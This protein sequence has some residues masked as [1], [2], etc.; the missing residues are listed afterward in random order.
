MCVASVIGAWILLTPPNGGPDEAGHMVRG[1]AVARGEPGSRRIEGAAWVVHPDVSCYALFADRPASCA[2]QQPGV[3]DEIVLETAANDYPIWGHVAVGLAIEVSSPDTSPYL[4]RAVS[5]LVPGTLLVASIVLAR[6]RSALAAALTLLAITPMAWFTIA[7]VNPSAL[8]IGGALALWVAIVFHPPS[9]PSALSD[10]LVG[11]LVVAGYAASLLPRRDG[12]IWTS[13]ILVAA[14]AATNTSFVAW[15]RRLGTAQRAVGIVAT[16]AACYW[17]FSN[18]GDPALT[19]IV[20]SAVVIGHELLRAG[21]ARVD[22]WVPRT[23][24]ATL[25]AVIAVVAG[26]TVVGARPGGYDNDLA[27]RIVRES[28]A[29]LREAIG[30]VATLDAKT[31]LWAVGLL[32]IALIFVA[33]CSVVGARAR[34]AD[35][36]PVIV[37]VAVVAVAAV[38]AWL[39]ELAQGNDSGTYWQG[40]YYLPFLMGVPILIGLPLV[41][42][43]D[44]RR[45]D[46]A[47]WVVAATMLVV[48]NVTFVVAA[49]RWGVGSGGSWH[50]SAWDTYGSPIAP[51]PL[52]V[53]H[54]AA[55][56][57]LAGLAVGPVGTGAHRRMTA[58]GPADR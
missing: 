12:A 54:L 50:P 25:V 13:L 45:Q 26:V 43:A 20:G 2:S 28:G 21:L 19:M 1:I 55:T 8:A 42:L 15:W 5:A 41:D 39:L 16:A 53:G 56:A 6:R 31:P 35:R 3:R 17:A 51:L 58:D 48:T 32:V 4:P 7:I 23:V 9:S 36:R 40:R 29:N 46:I 22:G 52:A 10:R 11:W 27:S 24:V 33:G 49:R 38:A 14:F 34:S 44:R 18:G 57:L 37:G 47:R 30:A